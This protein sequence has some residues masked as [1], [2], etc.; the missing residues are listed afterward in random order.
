MVRQAA[1]M[2]ALFGVW[3]ANV[4]AGQASASFQVGITIGSA[5]IKVATRL[6]TRSYTWG[7][8]AISVKLAGFAA[9]RRIERSDELYW[10]IARKGAGQYRVA[11][12]IAS[13][14]IVKVIP[15]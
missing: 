7:A 12:S 3:A 9:P 11:V 15:A 5:K 14:A 10:F 8:A 4:Q 6:V 13:G 2:A 1:V